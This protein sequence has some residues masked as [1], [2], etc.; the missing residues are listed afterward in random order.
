[1]DNHLR[2]NLLGSA[3]AKIALSIGTLAAMGAL[4]TGV[5]FA[6]THSSTPKTVPAI[7]GNTNTSGNTAIT[8][9][10]GTVNQTPDIPESGISASDPA[11]PNVGPEIQSGAQDTTG[12][13]TTTLA[14]DEGASSPEADTPGGVQSQ[15]G[16]Q[17]G[18][19]TDASSGN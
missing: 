6:S 4:G 3:K 11:G 16:S 9:N 12:L 10:T 7:T 18:G 8:G 14:P 15:V 19:I 1:M 17:V 13:D 2:R 5:A